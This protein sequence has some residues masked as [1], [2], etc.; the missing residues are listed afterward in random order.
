[1]RLLGLTKASYKAS[2]GFY[3]SRRV[4]LDLREAGETCSRHH[5][6]RLMRQNGI[7]ALH[8]CRPR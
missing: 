5:V 4:F 7:S 6:E 1:V 2:H 8:E 3:G